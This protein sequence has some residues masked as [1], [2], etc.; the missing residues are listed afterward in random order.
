MIGVAGGP[1]SKSVENGSNRAAWVGLTPKQHEA[2]RLLGSDARHV[3]LYGG[4]RSGKTFLLCRAIVVRALKSP[5][6]RHA[7]F[8]LRF[9]H[10]VRSVGLDTLPK[11]LK[12]CFPQVPY[13]TDKTEWIFRFP[14][15]SEIWLCG[16]DDKERTEKVLGQEFAT[17]YFNESS[18][19]P[20]ASVVMARTRLA[21][22][23]GLKL[24]AYY[25]C[26]PSGTAH[27]AYRTFIEKRDPTSKQPFANP[28]AF[29]SMVLNPGDNAANLAPEYIEELQNLPERQRKRFLE[30]RFVADLDNALWTLEMIEAGRHP[31][32]KELPPLTRVVVAVD[33]S[34][35]AGKEDK[36]SDEIGIAV[37]A[38]GVDDHYYVLEDASLRASP[39]QWA[40]RAILA[41]QTHK[42]DR[43]IAEKNFGG[44]MVEHTIKSVDNQVPITLITASRGKVQRAEPIAALYEKGLVHHVGVF[45]DLEDQLVNFTSAGYMGD[46]SPDR[47]DA[48]VW[49]LSELS[50]GNSVFYVGSGA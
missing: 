16:L 38:K 28:E 26:N 32:G 23:S 25:D 41:Y 45:E 10:V 47:A 24:K 34:G 12:L 39:E 30:G 31:K 19:I 46:R 14:N 5:G 2:N 11:V 48:D 35:A 42:A 49:A 27:W 44:A 8:R 6:S 1:E 7:I 20:F 37:A 9:N 13:T 21:Q 17:L 29:T 22:Q 50:Q 3:M 40:R 36:R 33:P 15:G 18:Q 4:S 43:I